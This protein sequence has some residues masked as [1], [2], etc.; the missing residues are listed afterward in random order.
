MRNSQWSAKGE[1]A[2][3][4][5]VRG[6]GRVES[7]ERVGTGIRGGVIVDGGESAVVEALAVKPSIANCLVEREP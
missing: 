7:A 4:A 1:D 3:D 5:I 6:L 2:G